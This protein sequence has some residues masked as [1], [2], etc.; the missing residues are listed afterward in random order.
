MWTSR[1]NKGG[2]GQVSTIEQFGLYFAGPRK[3]LKVWAERIRVSERWPS[4]VW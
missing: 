2:P 1:F 4:S 3:P